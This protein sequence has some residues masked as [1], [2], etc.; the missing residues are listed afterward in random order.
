[1]CPGRYLLA[2]GF[3]KRRLRVKFNS[4]RGLV[5]K[6]KFRPCGSVFKFHHRGRCR[7]NFAAMQVWH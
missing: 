2:C 6:F 4:S 3:C 1:M 7:L 5:F